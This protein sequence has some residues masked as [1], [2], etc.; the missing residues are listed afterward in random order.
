MLLMLYLPLSDICGYDTGRIP[1]K[2][3]VLE[4]SPTKVSTVRFQIPDMSRI[5]IINVYNLSAYT[6][7]PLPE[8][9][10][11]VGFRITDQTGIQM[12]KTSPIV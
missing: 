1:V 3:I 8:N 7:E 10:I 12:V 2:L 4:L 6:L 9:W 11:T 5:Q